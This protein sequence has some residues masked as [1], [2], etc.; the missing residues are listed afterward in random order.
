MRD[1]GERAGQPASFTFFFHFPVIMLPAAAGSALLD[2]P[3]MRQPAA[4][5]YWQFAGLVGACLL[6]MGLGARAVGAAVAVLAS[7]R[8]RPDRWDRL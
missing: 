1:T 8:T 3:L 2:Q 4:A 5:V 7:G 6:A